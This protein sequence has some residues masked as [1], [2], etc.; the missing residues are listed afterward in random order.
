MHVHEVV[1]SQVGRRAADRS[2]EAEAPRPVHVPDRSSQRAVRQLREP[3][4]GVRQSRVL[5][6]CREL[7]LELDAGPELVHPR[8]LPVL[9][10]PAA[11]QVEPRQTERAL[12]VP[13]CD[14]HEPIVHLQRRRIGLD[15]PGDLRGNRTQ[16]Q[17][18]EHHVLDDPV[19][20][21]RRSSSECLGEGGRT[22]RLELREVDMDPGQG[23]ANRLQQALLEFGEPVVRCDCRGDPAGDQL[24]VGCVGVGAARV[25]GHGFLAFQRTPVVCR[26]PTSP[27]GQPPAIVVQL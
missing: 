20:D 18:A 10:E 17:L 12:C 25:L 4:P 19:T 8:P 14:P 22:D 13:T 3:H 26:Q 23:R 7:V 1:L 2:G 11:L 9:G 6:T 24:S 16:H 21:R 27:A 15:P 5:D